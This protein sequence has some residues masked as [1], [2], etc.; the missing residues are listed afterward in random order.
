M[1]VPAKGNLKLET[2]NLGRRGIVLRIV[3]VLAGGLLMAA[4]FPPME[5]AEAA[6]VALVPFLLLA[7]FTGPMRSF[8]WGFAGGVVSWLLSIS[9]M[10]KLS[11]T[12]GYALLVV[13]G[14][15]LLSGYCAL[16]TGLF[17]MAASGLF[18][19]GGAESRTKNLALI[20]AIPVVWIGLEY[21]RSTLFTGFPWNP[22][23]VSQFRNLAVIQVAEW[24]GVYAVSAVIAVMNTALALTGLRL[25]GVYTRNQPSRLHVELMAGLLVCALCWMHGLR[26]AR[27]V[28]REA[29]ERT[30]VRVAAIQPNIPQVQKWPVDFAETIFERLDSL[31]QWAIHG[32][33]PQ[34]VVWPETATPGAIGGDPQS[35]K[36]TEDMARLGV[37]LLAGTLEVID[38]SPYSIRYYNSSFLY[39]ENANIVAR[40]RKRH[41]VPFGEYVPFA[42]TLGLGTRLA[43]LGFTCT[44]GTAPTVFR[45]KDPQTSFSA[46]ICFEDTVARLARESVAAG[47]GFLV[48]QTNDAWFDGT[49]APMQHMS[50]CVLRC[51]ENRVPAVRAAN[52]GVTCFIGSTGFV[53]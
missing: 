40:Y 47:A 37:P 49:A 33:K 35:T 24:G 9:W 21:L 39:D 15:I 42:E 12:G 10:L 22:L 17:T 11:Q 45:L 31:T 41:L 50:H 29:R 48:V 27:R 6:W 7:R 52:T 1:D 13:I 44:P 26:A 34:L 53:E 46:L 18:R 14:W 23:G 20:F 30:Q 38:D 32:S 5:G 25:V 51:V 28:G 36:F 8:R 3:A 43:P 16:Y 4:A 19:L 2:G